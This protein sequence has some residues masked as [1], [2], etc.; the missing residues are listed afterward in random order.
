MLEWIVAADKLAARYDCRGKSRQVGKENAQPA[1][2]STTPTANQTPGG[3]FVQPRA[4]LRTGTGE[5]APLPAAQASTDAASRS[6]LSADASLST[7]LQVKSGATVPHTPT[8]G[9]M[10]PTA[11][12]GSLLRDGDAAGRS[13]ECASEREASSAASTPQ[14]QFLPSGRGFTGAAAAMAAGVSASREGRVM[15]RSAEE[16]L[17]DLELSRREREREHEGVG[18]GAWSTGA[19]SVPRIRT[20]SETRPPAATAKPEARTP[21]EKSGA[22]GGG[23]SRAWSASSSLHSPSSSVDV[24]SRWVFRSNTAVE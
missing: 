23:S 19:D 1:G 8:A 13:M 15:E 21:G 20:P 22:S 4:S 2:G 18:A 24:S 9:A 5:A 3:D 16:M 17:C 7:M 11:A 14:A 12:G 6:L 10:R